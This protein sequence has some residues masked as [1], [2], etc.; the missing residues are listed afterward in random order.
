MQVQR[1]AEFVRPLVLCIAAVGALLLSSFRFAP[2]VAETVGD[3]PS[4]TVDHTDLR[5]GSTATV[6]GSGFAPGQVVDVSVCGTGVTVGTESCA[7]RHAFQVAANDDGKFIALVPIFRPPVNCPCHIRL[8]PLGAGEAVSVPIDIIGITDGAPT[9]PQVTS[10][11]L[12]IVDAHLDGDGPWTA[13]FGAPA[14]R[15]LVL[16]VV[17]RSPVAVVPLAITA[18]AGAGERPTELVVTGTPPVIPAGATVK[19][20]IPVTFEAFGH[21]RHRVAGQIIHAHGEVEFAVDVSLTPWGVVL[22]PAFVAFQVILLATWGFLRRRSPA[23][24]DTPA[25]LEALPD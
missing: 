19:I 8:A 21:G 12:E 3:T 7:F 14:A 5:L 2:L 16:V 18:F 15:T 1:R 17:N 13:F 9:P 20:L 11:T 24:V 10:E 23:E 4:A 6:R 22:V 25:D